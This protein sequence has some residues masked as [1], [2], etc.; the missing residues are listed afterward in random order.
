MLGFDLHR[1]ER[2]R[3]REKEQMWSH[4][5]LAARTLLVW[6]D[7]DTYS[8]WKGW[9]WGLRLGSLHGVQHGIQR[10][11][12]CFHSFGGKETVPWLSFGMMGV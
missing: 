8:S 4:V 1:L 7:S 12:H 3:K 5:V 11:V 6:V 9:F 2:L 10:N